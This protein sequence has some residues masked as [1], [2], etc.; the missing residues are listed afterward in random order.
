MKPFYVESEN[1]IHT[2]SFD[3]FAVVV[4][5]EIRIIFVKKLYLFGVYLV[6]KLIWLKL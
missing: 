3:L 1:K 2:Y 5:S 6:Y 4:L